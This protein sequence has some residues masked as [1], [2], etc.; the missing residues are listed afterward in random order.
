MAG[1]V[2]RQQLNGVGSPCKNCQK[3][4]EH[5]HSTCDVYLK[6]L[7]RYPNADC[8]NEVAKLYNEYCG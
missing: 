8:K 5:C 1:H 3:R 7:K 6:F 2:Y 4:K